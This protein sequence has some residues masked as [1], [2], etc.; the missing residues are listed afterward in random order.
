MGRWIKGLF[1]GGLLGV[2]AGVLFAPQKGEETRK[3]LSEAMD[4]AKK[5]GEDVKTKGEELASKAKQKI[6]EALEAEE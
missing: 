3:K 2:V 4:K 6:D 5:V 1:T